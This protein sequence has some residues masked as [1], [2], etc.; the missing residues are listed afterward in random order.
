MYKYPIAVLMLFATANLL[1]QEKEPERAEVDRLTD[2]VMAEGKALFRSEWASWHGTDIFLEKF[3]E[4]ENQ[5]GGYLSYETPANLINVFYSKGDKPRTVAVISFGKDFN[6]QNYQLDTIARP[7]NPIEQDLFALRAA[8]LRALKTDTTFKQYNNT[9]W[10]VI[11]FIN[12][13]AKRIYIVT[14][15][16]ELNVVAFGNDYLLNANAGNEIT[17][18]KRIH[19]SYIATNTKQNDVKALFH[20]HVIG[21]DEIMSA[22]DICTLMLYEKENNVKQAYVMSKKYVSIW[23]CGKDT[24]LVLTRQAWDRINKDQKAR[25]PDKQ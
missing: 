15:P 16:T 13:G 10:N 17:S 11:P 1:A 7:L 8:A 23:D 20:T 2:S 12:N 14:A 19:N 22:T 18:V 4:K 24:L 25:H 5:T 6:Q 3:K 9:D 21:K